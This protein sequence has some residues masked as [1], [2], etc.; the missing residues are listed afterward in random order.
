MS[1]HHV[2]KE[3]QEP[4]LLILSLE[5]FDLEN[6]G[7]LLEWSPTVIVTDEI[8]SQLEKLG[9][10]IDGVVTAF[11]DSSH[12]MH[13]RQIQMRDSYLESGINYFVEDKYPAVN[14][15]EREFNPESYQK[16]CKSINLVI[17]AGHQKI[18]P[19]K[20]GFSK[21]MMKGEKVKIFEPADN[22]SVNNLVSI[23]GDEFQ[24]ENDGFYSLNF[25]QP[26]IFV[27]ENY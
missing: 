23:T 9:I 2:V 18:F 11:P 4:G 12:Q 6:L 19:V 15:L 16:Y 5:K 3:R 20:S 1:S 14:V 27:A 8:Y 13:T 7:Q 22:L 10:K 24:V 17:Y 26:Y 25:D 21:W